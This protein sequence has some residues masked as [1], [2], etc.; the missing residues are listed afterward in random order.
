MSR[1]ISEFPKQPLPHVPHVPAPQR[2]PQMQAPT[3]FVYEKQQWEY[4][5]IRPNTDD[6][7]PSE[8]ELNALGR[9]GWELVSVIIVEGVAHFYLKRIAE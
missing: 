9:D 8:Q 3:V 2:H 4:K 7:R 1:N 6:A 5:I